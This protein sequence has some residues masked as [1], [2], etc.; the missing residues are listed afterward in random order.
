MMRHLSVTLLAV[1]ALG[2][3][4]VGGS[5]SSSVNKEALKPYILP[6][7]PADV[8]TKLDVD[9]EGKAKLL[10][11]KMTP[12]GNAGPGA[13][14]KLT[15]YW[16][17][18][19]NIGEGWNLFT[20]VLDAA[21]ERVLNVDNVGPLREWVDNHQ[22]LSPSFWEK[23]K[24]YVDE[25]TFR[26]PDQIT[27]PE[28]TVVTGIWKGDARMK[29]IAGPHDKE[30]R[31]IV[32]HI[33]TGVSNTPKPTTQAP[34][35]SLRVDKLAKGATITV[36]GKLN[37]EAWKT[38]AVAGPFVN[39]GDGSAVPD[40]APVKGTAK[41]TW[42]DKNLYV[43]FEIQSK[44]IVGGFPKD[45]KDPHLW[46]KDTVE[47]MVD[48][49]GD[50]DNLDYYEMQINPQNLVFDTRYEKYNEP[51]DDK[52]GLFGVMDWSAKLKSAVVIDGELDKADKGKGYV[53]EAA[54]PWT[55]FDKAKQTPPKPGDSWRMN[56]YG[57]KNNG[58]VAWSPI[59]NQGNFHKASRFGRV[60]WAIPGEPLPATSGS[61]AASSSA[62]AASASAPK[63][64]ASAPKPPLPPIAK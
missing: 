57:M 4:C 10:G 6:A 15:L 30:N 64:G 34:I 32:A 46:E 42:D 63:P 31:A 22:A 49:D 47:M 54:I 56:F 55:S 14:V 13:E 29:P 50:G 26:L 1:A 33:K 61:A 12:A 39:V 3:G 28:L 52:K 20:H 8:G 27:T 60:I 41:L 19:E 51:K 5:K 38:A 59:L 35:K 24:V 58:G 9:F 25:Q 44:H 18:T 16:Q 36:D 11:Y 45:A 17:A 48:P 2:L 37:E 62:P 21:G 23:G 7:A 53:V 43:A 40:S